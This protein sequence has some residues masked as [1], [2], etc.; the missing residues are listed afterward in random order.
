LVVLG[1]VNPGADL[2]AGGD[3]IVFGSLRGTA[4][5]SAYDD[6]ARDKVII[7][8]KMQ[9]SQLRIGSVISRGSDDQ[10]AS[11]EIARIDD[12]KIIVEP[13]SPRSLPLR[14]RG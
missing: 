12:R 5:A 13:Y 14:K 4:H 10:I 9:P 1:D 7:A 2:T 3:I 11:A 6:E 8:L